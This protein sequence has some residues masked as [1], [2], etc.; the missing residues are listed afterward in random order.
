LRAALLSLTG[1]ARSNDHDSQL[2]ADI[3][4]K[5]P[6]GLPLFV[7]CKGV[8]ATRDRFFLNYAERGGAALIT[9]YDRSLWP[10]L[11]SAAG[12][13][14]DPVMVPLATLVE[15][16]QLHST[17]RKVQRGNTGHTI[18]ELL[19]ALAK[20]M[21]DDGG[22]GAKTLKLVM[23][24]LQ[25]ATD[26]HWE[27]IPDDYL[28]RQYNWIWDV[29]PGRDAFRLARMVL[30][31]YSPTLFE[32]ANGAWDA[33]NVVT[34]TYTAGGS[35]IDCTRN[36][37][38]AFG[39]QSFGALA[40]ALGVIGRDA[41]GNVLR[42]LVDAVSQPRNYIR[43]ALTAGYFAY[44]TFLTYAPMEIPNRA[45]LLEINQKYLTA[46]V[47]GMLMDV[48]KDVGIQALIMR[49]EFDHRGLQLSVPGEPADL[50][51]LSKADRIAL[52]LAKL[53]VNVK[54]A[55]IQLLDES[56]RRR[57]FM[58]L[59]GLGQE[60]LPG[61]GN[62]F[63]PDGPGVPAKPEYDPLDPDNQGEDMSGKPGDESEPI[64]WAV[65]DDERVALHAPRFRNVAS[66]AHVSPITGRRIDV[67]SD[68]AAWEKMVHNDPAFVA[69]CLEQIANLAT[70]RR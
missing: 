53:D 21:H 36:V 23:R 51:A 50:G 52:E 62:P 22:P 33:V 30:H 61:G 3:A 31:G 27:D 68:V 16:K 69:F 5:L 55:F 46:T 65:I 60:M 19:T 6:G 41:A 9:Q 35:L 12:Q 67:P 8:A 39:A 24:T 47:R 10:E 42:R 44:D 18:V 37:G 48:I 25:Q 58:K 54:N 11:V 64:A 1:Y 13:Y 4:M 20:A 66:E 59:L 14:G 2:V 63:S 70:S 26:N 32:A 38:A 40:E 56:E 34:F 15:E 29:L 49:P 17:L 43:L 28:S 7:E 57:S 45:R